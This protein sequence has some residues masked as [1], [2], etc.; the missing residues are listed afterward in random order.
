MGL[1]VILF[2][3][4]LDKP[5][6][7]VINSFIVD[8]V[9]FGFCL[10]LLFLQPEKY[11]NSKSLKS[12]K[13][14]FRREKFRSFLMSCLTQINHWNKPTQYK[15]QFFFSFF[16]VF[17]SLFFLLSHPMY[18]PSVMPFRARKKHRWMA[19]KVCSKDSAYLR[20][21]LEEIKNHYIKEEG[22]SRYFFAKINSNYI[23]KEIT[24]IQTLI[25][26]RYKI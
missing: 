1:F 18:H 4:F 5:S 25:P 2:N 10:I 11:S 21:A 16:D 12:F 14:F 19:Q 24:W 22:A 3:C 9:G 17:L 26:L 23:L 13:L 20:E 6:T 15:E 7:N 8:T